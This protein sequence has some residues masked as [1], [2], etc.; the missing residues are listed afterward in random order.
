MINEQDCPMQ[1]DLLVIAGA[2]GFI[3]GSLAKYF[4]SKGFRR[5]RGVDKKPLSSWYQRVPGVECLCMDLS[6][7]QMPSAPS[8]GQ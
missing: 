5:I 3:G 2:G 4:R 1:D 7:M 6:E 8:R